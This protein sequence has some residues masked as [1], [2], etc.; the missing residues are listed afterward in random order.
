M[1]NYYY[2]RLYQFSISFLKLEDGL[3]WDTEITFDSLFIEKS[4][5]RQ[6]YLLQLDCVAKGIGVKE[7]LNDSY[8]IKKP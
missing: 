2:P 8:I 3:D 5:V 1:F 7:L 6:N 4:R